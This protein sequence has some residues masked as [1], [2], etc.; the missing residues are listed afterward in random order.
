M[1]TVS[2]ESSARSYLELVLAVIGEDFEHSEQIVS[3]SATR[4]LFLCGPNRRFRCLFLLLFAAA[5]CG[6][7]LSIRPKVNC[8]SVWNR[9]AAD[10]S[11]I[12]VMTQELERMYTAANVVG[13][14]LHAVGDTSKSGGAKAKGK[15][16]GQKAASTATGA[17]QQQQQQDKPARKPSHNRSMSVASKPHAPSAIVVTRMLAE[18]SGNV[19]S[20]DEATTATSSSS[21]SSS[22]AATATAAAVAATSASSNLSPSSTTSSSFSSSSSSN[23][24]SPSPSP[25]PLSHNGAF[26]S[27]QQQQQ[28]QHHHRRAMSYGGSARVSFI[29]VCLLF[30]YII[31]YMI[32]S[33]FF[34]F[35]AIDSIVAL[36]TTFRFVNFIIIIIIKNNLHKTKT[37]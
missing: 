31:N 3:V 10:K 11:A 25:S 29:C 33:L 1:I 23:S 6:V 9:S 13:Y 14:M 4:C 34:V 2:K 8:L 7:V 36:A 32:E 5:Q 20:G 12:A 24:F 30:V 15:S 28:Q 37:Q 16:S 19:S 35:F 22:T 21:S 17:Q 26:N 18:S 27:L